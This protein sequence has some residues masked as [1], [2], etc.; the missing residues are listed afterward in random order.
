[1]WKLVVLDE[2]PDRRLYC[3]VLFVGKLNRRQ[4]QLPPVDPA[5]HGVLM[6]FRHFIASRNGGATNKAFPIAI[7]A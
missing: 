2:A 3:G 6:A 7:D 1:V 4:G 5:L